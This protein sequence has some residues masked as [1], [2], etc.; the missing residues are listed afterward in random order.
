[1]TSNLEQA[2]KY[3]SR[4]WSVFPV[5]PKDKVPA[6]ASWAVY[7]ER[8]PTA[9]EVIGW[10]SEN[11]NYN[12]AIVCGKVSNLIVIDL[13]KG[14]GEPDLMGLELPPTLSSITGGNGT[15]VY[16]KWRPGL[17]GNKV[18]YRTFVDIRSDNGY[19]V[20]PPS[21]HKSGNYYSWN[22][23]DEIIAD[24]PK[25]LEAEHQDSREK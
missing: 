9:T 3:V 2:L 22:D 5:K 19:V 25:W 8:L 16:Y 14:K 6:I 20:A 1:M 17:I 13:D 11:P 18:G 23:E 10:W 15:H 4:G 21:L 24:V 7:A 12:I